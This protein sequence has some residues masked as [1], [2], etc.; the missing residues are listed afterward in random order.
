MDATQKLYDVFWQGLLQATGHVG[1]NKND[2]FRQFF[3]ELCVSL[4]TRLV[5]EVGAHGAE[6]SQEIARL[7]PDA[8]VLAFEA[9]PYVYERFGPSMMSGVD[10]RNTLVSTDD[11]DRHIFIP[12]VIKRPRQDDLNLQQVN[13]V[14]GMKKRLRD[15]EYDE[16]LCKSVTVDQISAEFDWSE[17]CALWIDGEGAAGEVL[18]G[19]QQSLE[20][21]IAIL[22]I[23]LET[24]KAWESQWINAD[25]R[26]H[27]KTR[28]FVPL[29]RD[30]ETEWQYNE[31]YIRQDMLTDELLQSTRGFIRSLTMTRTDSKT[32]IRG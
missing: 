7:L 30:Y 12:R 9:N 20:K 22:Q 3:T 23:E 29:C 27:L 14:S 18:F 25:V 13:P 17:P 2:F 4:Q 6:F 16:V 24:R 11:R 31:I 19:A 21:N 8:R 26:Q 28:G 10:Y 5:L 32:A 15:V 1:R